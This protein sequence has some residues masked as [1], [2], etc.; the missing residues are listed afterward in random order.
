MHIFHLR[1]YIKRILLE[2]KCETQ[3]CNV[4]KNLSNIDLNSSILWYGRDKLVKLI[5]SK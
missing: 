2:K 5:F 3:M 1:N 4:T